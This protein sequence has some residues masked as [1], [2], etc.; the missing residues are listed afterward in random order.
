MA[1]LEEI[2]R[3]YGEYLAEARE[4]EA[5]L[6]PL[7]G[8]LGFGHKSSDDP[9]HERFAQELETLLKSAPAEVI[10][11]G[12]L[13]AMLE[14]IYRAPKENREP[15]AVYWMLTAVHGLTPELAGRLGRED[16]QAL[17]DE[18]RAAYPR[19]DRLPAQKKV[20]AALDAAR[21]GK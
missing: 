12:E 1:G 17:W 16:A 13:R 9:C 4:A 5:K 8:V 14:Y 6:R 15:L 19:W 3:L 18:Y 2:R 21:K 20:L 7:D 10:D 11:S